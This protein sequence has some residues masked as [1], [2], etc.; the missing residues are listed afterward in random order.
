MPAQRKKELGMKKLIFTLVA[1]LTMTFA[2]AQNQK[3]A[4]K[5]NGYQG[6]TKIEAAA[7]AVPGVKQATYE[8]KTKT[9][10]VVYDKK[11]TTAAKV[12]QA[13]LKAD[14]K[15]TAKTPSKASAKKAPAK[16]SSQN[17]QASAPAKQPLPQSKDNSRK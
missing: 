1:M 17:K 5:V 10:K 16:T 3:T 15:P 11:K 6:K 12:K 2:V 8:E 7:K 4:I 13:V 14:K 9:V